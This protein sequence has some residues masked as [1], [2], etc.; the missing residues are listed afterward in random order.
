MRFTAL[1]SNV[2]QT[3]RALGCVFLLFLLLINA[4]GQ[5]NGATITVW[6]CNP[7]PQREWKVKARVFTRSFFCHP[8]LMKTH[9]EEPYQKDYFQRKLNEA[10]QESNLTIQYEEQTVI[11]D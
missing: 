4:C 8:G 11:K 5:I 2:S 9:T 1:E 3:E 10:S 7:T 6:I